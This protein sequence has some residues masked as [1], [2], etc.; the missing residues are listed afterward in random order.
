MYG[1]QNYKEDCDNV[2]GKLVLGKW[3]VETNGIECL[4]IKIL[5]VGSKPKFSLLGIFE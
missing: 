1:S 3:D 5:N 2:V 4:Y